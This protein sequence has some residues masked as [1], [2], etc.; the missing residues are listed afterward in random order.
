M[1]K[2][3]VL[4]FCFT[5]I[6]FAQNTYDANEN[7]ETNSNSMEVEQPKAQSIF[8]SY[9]NVPTNVFIGEMF[10]I[11]VKA[12]IASKDFE[13]ITNSF[14]DSQN[15]QIINPDSS[16]QWYSDNIFYNT[17]YMKANNINAKLPSLS[18]NI[19]QDSHRIDTETLEATTPNIIKLN[20]TKLFSGVIAKSL[21]IKKNKTTQFD[22]KSYI[23]V[24]EI[25]AEQSNLG[26][27][28]L[29]WVTRDGIDSSSENIPFYKI[30]YY[31]IVPDFT[32]E[33]I[34]TY[35][36]RVN[37]KFEK[38]T[39]PIVVADQKISTQIDLNPAQSS[40]QI[41]KDGAYVF[42][43]LLLIALYI[44]RRKISYIIFFIVLISFIVY[45]KNPLNSIKIDSGS[46]IK[47]LPTKKSTIFYVTDRTLYAQ[48]LD[49]KDN[50]TKILLPNG[51]IGWI[52]DSKN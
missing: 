6:A 5:T 3:L 37:N 30:F 40:L 45:E 1:K 24:L 48:K 15:I 34:F 8:L 22:N 49:T 50:Y 36:N 12:I 16:W 41:Y 44:K 26:D 28:S 17:F 47:I 20:G 33:F 7:N 19:Y 23:V 35:F 39:I 31:A 25:E 9:E 21:K 51:K 43:V 4:F 42:L 29:K 27:F 2:L 14:K 13:E 52:S 10:S 11:K 32:K 38:I 18:L 46:K